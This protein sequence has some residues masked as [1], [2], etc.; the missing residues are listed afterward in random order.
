MGLAYALTPGKHKEAV[1]VLRSGFGIFYNRFGVSNLLTAVRQNG[2]SQLAY[3]VQDP[4]FFCTTQACVAAEVG[5]LLVAQPT[6]PTVYRVRPDLHAAYAM[7]GSFSVE[8]GFSNDKGVI[9]ATYIATRGVHQYLSENIN[10]PL[11]GTYNPEDASSGVRP[12]GGT[13]NIYEFV[14]E[15]VRHGQ[16]LS[17][18]ADLNPT[19]AL[20]VWAF[21]TLQFRE[22]DTSGATSFPSNQYDLAADYG[23]TTASR[24]RLFSG[25]WYNFPRAFMGGLFFRTNSGTPFNITTGTDGNG[26]TIFNDRPSFATDMTR[27]SVAR[28][29]YGNFD[30]EPVAGQTV[31]PVRS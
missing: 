16:T 24:E 26:D 27:R 10:A 17:A 19:K 14:S 6:A 22:A 12:L 21:Y 13:Q 28:T 25:L 31:I 23:R 3:L 29:R 4:S 18:A 8:H 9:S 5:S 20:S 11:P 7:T 1:A 15:G 30:T 2:V